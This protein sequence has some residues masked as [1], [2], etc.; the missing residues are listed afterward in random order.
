MP[1]FY[2]NQSLAIPGAYTFVDP[3]G[4]TLPGQGNEGLVFLVGSSVGGAP[5]QVLTFSD[6]ASAARHLRGGDLLNAYN[7]AT[8]K[9]GAQSVAVWRTDP[10]TP[11]Y[12]TVYGNSG[13]VS[14]TLQANDSGAYTNQFALAIAGS[15]GNQTVTFVD[16]Y[17]NRTFTQSGLGPAFSVQ[18][19]G[20]AT[21]ASGSV[22]NGLTMGTTTLTAGTTGQ[23]PTGTYGVVVDVKNAASLALSQATTITLSGTQNAINTTWSAVTGAFT[24]D[25]Y[26]SGTQGYS[27]IASVPATTSTNQSYTITLSGTPTSL[28]SPISGP[29]FVSL[30]SGQTDGSVNQN[31]AITQVN[32]LVALLNVQ[33]GYVASTTSSVSASIPGYLL[34]TSGNE[35]LLG[36]SGYTFTANLG[37]VV[38]YIQSLGYATPTVP[39]GTLVSPVAM[40]LTN[41][42]GGEDG[43]QTA[44][45][46]SAVANALTTMHPFPRYT[47]AL[48]SVNEFIAPLAN[49]VTT[50]SETFPAMLSELFIGGSSN[51]NYT[52]AVQRSAQFASQRIINTGLDF[53]DYDYTLS[54]THFPSYMLAAIYAGLRASIGAPNALTNQVLNIKALGSVPSAPQ[55][56]QYL[57][58]NVAIPMVNALGQIVIA[59]GVTTSGDHVNLYY[60]EESIVNAADTLRL[61]LIRETAAGRTQ[62]QGGL[63]G[64]VNYGT[65]TL[66]A[67]MGYLNSLL[68]K[69]EDWG[70]IASFQRITNITSIGGNPEYELIPIKVAIPIPTNGMVFN[71]ELTIPVG[72]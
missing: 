27:Y 25:V 72:L 68:K 26:L 2:D 21:T 63:I 69:A 35:S 43:S 20:N 1:V 51:P 48:T 16:G 70:W 41:F 50:G 5:G 56:T 60:R 4:L 10:A 29:A 55:I 31:I 17:A 62:N 14:F 44:T 19:T 59:R 15:A 54:Y 66:G 61:Y 64:Q 18:Y 23:L 9:G 6:P 38:T 36:T 53:W 22:T 33:Q 13:Q 7:F 65:A 30:L 47:V 52:D 67:R 49:A 24:Y 45:Q 37:A 32:A 58:N 3:N 40:A 8:Q 39:A 12:L 11:S 28:P 34:D 71:L 57:E 42:L 46:W